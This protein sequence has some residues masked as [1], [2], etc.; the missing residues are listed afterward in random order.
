MVEAD[1]YLSRPINIRTCHFF[2]GRIGISEVSE[3]AVRTGRASAD[4]TQQFVD[5]SR[6]KI[7]E[8]TTSKPK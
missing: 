3:F 6:N 2:S 5:W 7:E 8:M 1:F 4:Q